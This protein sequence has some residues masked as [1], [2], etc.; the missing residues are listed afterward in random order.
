MELNRYFDFT[1][2]MMVRTS[3]EPSSL[4]CGKTGANTRLMTPNLELSL[5]QGETSTQMSLRSL[6][7]SSSDSSSRFHG[8]GAFLRHSLSPSEPCFS[9][10]AFNPMITEQQDTDTHFVDQSSSP[11][12]ITF[13]R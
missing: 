1:M 13:L 3:E 10:E 4:L 6:I 12:L 9:G 11:Q 2:Q 7:P 5:G 8:D